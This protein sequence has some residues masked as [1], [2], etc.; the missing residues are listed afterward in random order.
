[1]LFIPEATV[2]DERFEDGNPGLTDVTYGKYFEI[3][4]EEGAKILLIAFLV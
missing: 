4:F 2:L 3:S 1:M